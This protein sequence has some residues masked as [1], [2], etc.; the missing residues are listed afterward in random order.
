MKKTPCDLEGTGALLFA[1]DNERI[2]YVRLATECARRVREHLRIPVSI[3][4]SRSLSTR[5]AS[6]FHCVISSDTSPSYSNQKMF[7]DFKE[8]LEF[9]NHDRCN[10]LAFTPYRRT[11]MIDVDLL[12]QTNSL[13][14]AWSGDG[15]ALPT[16]AYSV[17]GEDLSQDMRILSHSSG[18]PMRWATVVCFDKESDVARQFFKNWQQARRFYSAYSSIYGFSERPLRNDFCVT[19]AAERMSGGGQ[20]ME[21]N[22]EI[23]TLMPAIEVSSLE[24]IRVTDPNGFVSR[25]VSDVHVMNKKSILSCIQNSQRASAQD[26]SQQSE[27]AVLLPQLRSVARLLGLSR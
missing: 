1:H 27:S 14:H 21:L 7:Y 13:R 4:T 10:A 11:Y 17:Q 2:D 3:V 19:I 18:V 8:N 22:Y 6:P 12:L 5:E 24:P 23:P 20:S 25:I 9:W 15:V 16:R 26:S